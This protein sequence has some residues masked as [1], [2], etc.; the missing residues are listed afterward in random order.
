M[1]AKRKKRIEA[2]GLRND[3]ISVS[4]AINDFKTLYAA[5]CAAK[6]DESVEVVIALAVDVRQSDQSVRGALEIPHGWRNVKV[7]AL[8]GPDKFEEAKN[9]GA[10]IVGSSEL[11]EDV[12]S[13]KITR[14]DFD[15]CVA[16]P[17]MMGK[18]GALGK[19]LG[20]MG[21]MPNPKLGKV[22][23]DIAYAIKRVKAGLVEFKT[24][25]GGL[26]HA[27]VGKMSFSTDA[28]K[29]NISAFYNAVVAAKPSACKGG[30][31]VKKMYLS[32]SMGPSLSIDLSSLMV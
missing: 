24:D 25:K 27:A 13:G 26:V 28:L 6:F 21:L 19:I 8:V 18:V 29:D 10:D 15:D 14:K 23:A 3:P 12:K 1:S 16:T 7:L 5:G 31:Y 11:I 9:A 32:S 2:L 20:P 4:A 17:D 22:D 30:I